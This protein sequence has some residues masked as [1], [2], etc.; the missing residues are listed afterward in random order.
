MDRR[1]RCQVSL[2]QRCRGRWAARRSAGPEAVPPPPATGRDSWKSE[3]LRTS[4][5]TGRTVSC[6]RMPASGT[7]RV[8]RHPA[9]PAMFRFGSDAPVGPRE[10]AGEPPS[11][12][13]RDVSQAGFDGVRPA[14]ESESDLRL[15]EPC[16]RS[17]TNAQTRIKVQRFASA[18]SKGAARVRIRRASL[19]REEVVA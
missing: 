3:L 10:A 19:T 9:A 14:L 4:S 7:E 2:K 5:Y 18:L 11:W 15:V 8:G 13:Q 12:M 6:G 17:G 16:K 1:P